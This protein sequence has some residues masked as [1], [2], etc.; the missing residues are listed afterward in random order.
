MWRSGTAAAPCYKL[1]AMR[2]DDQLF[3]QDQVSICVLSSRKLTRTQ[4]RDV[5]RLSAPRLKVVM[6]MQ[7]GSLNGRR[8][9]SGDVKRRRPA[10]LARSSAKLSSGGRAREKT[11][12]AGTV[13]LNHLCQC[14][15]QHF[16][17]VGKGC[18]LQSLEGRGLLVL[19]HIN[20]INS[21]FAMLETSQ[22][23]FAL[24]RW[25]RN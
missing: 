8:G 14:A 17:R 25:E 6:G 2:Q 12:G 11:P 1:I 13:L 7:G 19:T 24:Q 23:L 22:G 4:A 21:L 3:P 9:G 16:R 10:S 20:P 15:E 18:C 5:S